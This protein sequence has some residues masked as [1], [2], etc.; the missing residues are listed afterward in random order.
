MLIASAA[1]LAGAGAGVAIGSVTPTVGGGADVGPGKASTYP[2]VGGSNTLAEPAA[3]G[4]PAPPRQFARN[5]SLSFGCQAREPRSTSQAAASDASGFGAGVV[6]FGV[7]TARAAEVG[8]RAA[9][10]TRE[11]AVRRGC[12]TASSRGAS[13]PPLPPGRSKTVTIAAI[14]SRPAMAHPLKIM[15][16]SHHEPS[17]H[18]QE[19]LQR[20]QWCYWRLPQRCRLT[21]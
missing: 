7:A 11:T 14:A 9:P 4:R 5:H 21:P 19:Y 18:P 3:E 8:V 15:P 2:P 13:S 12:A 6:A 20:A 16:R 10:S 1:W 17:I